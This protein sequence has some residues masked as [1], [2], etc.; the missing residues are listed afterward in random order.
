MKPNP[1]VWSEIYVQD[2]A[3]AQRFYESVFQCKLEAPNVPVEDAHG[4]QMLFFPSDNMSSYGSA[5]AL[6]KMEGV[7]SG[8]GGTLVYLSCDD[9]AVEQ[10]RAEAAGGKVFKPKFSIAPHGFIALV[11]DTEG[12][13]IGLHSMK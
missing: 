9:C 11:V 3:R 13:C 12:N 5:G 4:M 1:F 10:A 6:V 8:G 2:M 7:P